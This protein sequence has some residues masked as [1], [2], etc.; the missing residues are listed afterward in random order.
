MRKSESLLFLAW[1]LS[2]VATLT[3]L[4]FSEFMK[5]PPC[6][7]CWYQRICMYPLVVILG[8]AF[9]TQDSNHHRYS[10][11][12]IGA[13]WLLALYHN[14]L[15]YKIIPEKLAP[16]SAGASCTDKQLELF[17]FLTIPLMSLLTFTALFILIAL[18]R[19]NRTTS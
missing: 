1:L 7:L 10:L 11:P 13:G 12:L 17:G 15:Y 6:N 16:C 3:S 5:L 18:H 2:L 14:L 9:S 19:K 4:F 8:V